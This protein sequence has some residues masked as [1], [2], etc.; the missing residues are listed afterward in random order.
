MSVSAAMPSLLARLGPIEPSEVSSAVAL[1]KTLYNQYVQLLDATLR[2]AGPALNAVGAQPVHP[3]YVATYSWCFDNLSGITSWDNAYGAKLMGASPSVS[4]DKWVSPAAGNDPTF[5]SERGIAGP[6]TGSR[7]EQIGL[8]A[9]GTGVGATLFT[10]QSSAHII[11][12]AIT[13]GYFTRT[14]SVKFEIVTGHGADKVTT[15]TN[16]GTY[17]ST[18]ALPLLAT[19]QAVLKNLS[20]RLRATSIVG[21]ALELEVWSLLLS[22]SADVTQFVLDKMEVLR[23]PLGSP[24]Y[25]PPSSVSAVRDAM[26]NSVIDSYRKI[27]YSSRFVTP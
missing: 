24:I 8:G 18:I 11:N 23:D 21:A 1:Y 27:T 6:F 9:F 7:I 17:T 15:V 3:N 4:Q 14:L 10:A 12:T 20:D 26:I 25:L 13:N 22:C 2:V 16:W 5:F 19:Y